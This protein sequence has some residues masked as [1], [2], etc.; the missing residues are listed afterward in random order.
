MLPEVSI[1]Q[2]EYPIA[3]LSLNTHEAH[4]AC[5]GDES[6]IIRMA[7]SA[8]GISLGESA[9]A[10]VRAKS[11]RAEFTVSNTETSIV[12]KKSS[13]TVVQTLSVS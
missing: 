9:V 1:E 7:S 13:S 5:S 11:D 8:N 12:T 2:F 6:F 4:G 3:L 10:F